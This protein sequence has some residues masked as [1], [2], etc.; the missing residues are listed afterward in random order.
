MTNFIARLGYLLLV[1]GLFGSCQK[2]KVFILVETAKLEHLDSLYRQNN[3]E[4]DPGG[5]ICASLKEEILGITPTAEAA[6]RS[7]NQV[8]TDPPCERG[9]Q[10]QAPVPVTD[11]EIGF[12]DQGQDIRLQFYREGNLV[13]V[14]GQMEEIEI[15]GID[16][17]ICT[18]QKVQGTDASGFGE[19]TLVV[20]E[21]FP[22]QEA[23][24]YSVLLTH[25]LIGL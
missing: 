1:A 20:N 17:K 5:G 18:M 16:F 7:V 25:S 12:T 3:C 22:G 4:G 2:E 11:T 13:A 6:R 19:I 24:T 15:N 23:K 10:S 14:C 9:K 21:I 8:C